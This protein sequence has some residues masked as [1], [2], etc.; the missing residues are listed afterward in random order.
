MIAAVNC[1]PLIL[2]VSAI[3]YLLCTSQSRHIEALINQCVAAAAAGYACFVI[4]MMLLLSDVKKIF[5][6]IMI[7]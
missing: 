5:S 3:V 4:L 6:S 7:F 2:F 1:E